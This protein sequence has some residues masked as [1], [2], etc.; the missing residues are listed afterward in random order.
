[1]KQISVEEAIEHIIEEV[2]DNLLEAFFEDQTII[3][4][5]YYDKFGEEIEIVEG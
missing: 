1:M 4:Q 3:E 2:R 5:L